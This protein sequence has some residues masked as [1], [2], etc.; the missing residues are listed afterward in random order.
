[1]TRTSSRAL[2]PVAFCA[3]LLCASTGRALTMNKI[4]DAALGRI[5]FASPLTG[6]VVMGTNG[7]KQY[8]GAFTGPLT[9]VAGAVEVVDTAGTQVDISCTGAALADASGQTVA[10]EV[11]IAVGAGARGSWGTN[12]ACTDL[13]TVAQTFT[14]TSSGTDNTLYFGLR[15]APTS[16]NGGSYSTSNPNGQAVAVQAVVH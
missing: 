15:M 11:E 6:D 14:L 9:G 4:A 2:L 13:S 16:L 7:L 10:A 8:S 1:M 5:E 3:A 12:T